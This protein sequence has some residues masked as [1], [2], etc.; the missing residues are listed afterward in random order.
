MTFSFYCPRP[1]PGL[2]LLPMPAV[3]H[4]TGNKRGALSYPSFVL[5][6]A[7]EAATTWSPSQCASQE[8]KGLSQTLCPDMTL[9]PLH[10]ISLEEAEILSFW[11]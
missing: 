7:A 4:R 1:S 10:P 5:G 2:I 3:D 11:L 6:K 9:L 8:K